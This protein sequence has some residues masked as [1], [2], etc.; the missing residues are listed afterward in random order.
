M[1]K[2]FTIAIHGAPYSSQASHH[3]LKLTEALLAQGHEISRVFFFHDGVMNA[4]NARV[5]PQEEQDQAQG[6][7]ALA[8]THGVELAVCIAN[9]LK[10]GVVS[11]AERDRYDTPTATLAAPFELVGLGQLIEAIATSDRYVEI[12]A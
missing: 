7:Q 11:E 12:P 1:S 5:P 3:G 9:A 4:L 2:T 8:D 10:R 6:W